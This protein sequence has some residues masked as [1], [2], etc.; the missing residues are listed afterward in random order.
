MKILISNFKNENSHVF[1]IHVVVW[2]I[3]FKFQK[4]F[5]SNFKNDF[6]Q[7][8]HGGTVKEPKKYLYRST[9]MGLIFSETSRTYESKCG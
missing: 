6:F 5:I 7:N 9:S 2:P 3:F 4:K 8:F 1:H